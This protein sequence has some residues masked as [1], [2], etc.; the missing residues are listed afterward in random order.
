MQVGS[1]PKLGDALSLSI[2]CGDCGHSRWRRSQEF[3]R[4]GFRASTPIEEVS[5]ALSC[6][7]CKEVGLPGKN[8]V[9]QV[10]FVDLV[11]QRK[12]EAWAS[13][14]SQRVRAAG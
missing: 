6:S 13:A 12:G 9:V 1:A 11:A 4:Y 10:A 8:V 7:P 14:K 3:Y 2:E 5:R